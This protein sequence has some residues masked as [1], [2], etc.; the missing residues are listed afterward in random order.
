MVKSKNVKPFKVR[1]TCIHRSQSPISEITK[2]GWYL[3]DTTQSLGLLAAGEVDIAV[4]YNEAAERQAIASQT[5]L[6]SVYGFRVGV[7]ILGILSLICYL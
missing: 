5:A 7:I 4:T 3:G 2:I 1:I 6:K